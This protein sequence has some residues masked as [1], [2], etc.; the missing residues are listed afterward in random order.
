MPQSHI[1]RGRNF[2]GKS[3]GRDISAAARGE[4]EGDKELSAGS[5]LRSCGAAGIAR[6]PCRS[7]A[8]RLHPAT[9]DQKRALVVISEAFSEYVTLI[10]PLC[11]VNHTTEEIKSPAINKFSLRINNKWTQSLFWY[12]IL[13]FS[14][15]INDIEL[16]K[17]CLEIAV[18]IKAMARNARSLRKWCDPKRRVLLMHTPGMLIRPRCWTAGE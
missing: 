13:Y 11:Y 7:S 5:C 18:R 6:R 12:A 9:T 2:W 10:S 17:F 8:R 1:K 4:R 3:P 16:L 14:H 15:E